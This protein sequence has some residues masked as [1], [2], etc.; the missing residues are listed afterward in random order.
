MK[1]RQKN[2]RQLIYLGVLLGLITAFALIDNRGNDGFDFNKNEFTLG[3]NTV[4][5][6]VILEG[7][8]G[9]NQFEYLNGAWQVNGNYLMDEG[10][11]DVFFALLSRLEVK[12]P[13]AQSE[14]DS[15]ATYLRTRGTRVSIINNADTIKSY[16]VGGN[17]FRFQ[18]YLMDPVAGLPYL[19]HIPG[20]QSYLAGI[21]EAQE[22][23]WRSRYIWDLDWTSLK[24]LTVDYKGAQEPLLFEY[25]DNFMAMEGVDLLDTANMMGYLEFIAYLQTDKYLLPDEI[26]VYDQSILSNEPL[27]SIDVEKIGDRKSSLR[28]FPIPDGKKYYPGLLNQEQIVLFQ[29]TVVENMQASPSDFE[30]TE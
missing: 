6:T 17:E 7:P 23:D 4:I 10:M 9:K 5:T 14:S 18:S 25:R 26:V 27:L 19:V 16:L 15:L 29:S 8:E 24:K 3:E 1:Q 22:N 20:Y 30:L 13:V 11:R 21:F 28:L 12:R 2:I